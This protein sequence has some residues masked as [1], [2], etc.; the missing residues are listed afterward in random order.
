M[1]AD[2]RIDNK[3]MVFHGGNVL[4][5]NSHIQEIP[6]NG[7]DAAHLMAVHGDTVLSGAS[8]GQRSWLWS[9]CG[10]HGWEGNW[11][12]RPEESQKH[13]AMSELK[14]YLRFFNKYRLFD[15]DIVAEQMGPGLV[16]LNLTSSFGNFLIIQTVTPIAPLLQRVT[17][18]VFASRQLF[19]HSKI[20]VYAETVMVRGIV[21]INQKDIQDVFRLIHRSSGTSRCGTTSST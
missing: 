12:A 5:V 9:L 18:R 6:E 1:P 14:H 17:H 15:V 10:S 3:E 13:V 2:P 4:W 20:L 8:C 21:L 7:A 16:R 19:L 11:Y